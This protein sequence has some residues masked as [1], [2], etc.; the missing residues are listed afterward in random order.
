[1]WWCT[2]LI[3]A[4][5]RQRQG[6][7][8]VRGQP[9]L[10]SE[11]QDSQSYIEKPCLEN[12]QTKE[13]KTKKQKRNKKKRS[14]RKF[15][16]IS[17]SQQKFTYLV[18]RNSSNRNCS[19]TSRKSQRPGIPWCPKPGWAAPVGLRGPLPCTVATWHISSLFK[20]QVTG[21]AWWH[22]PLIPAL[23]RQRQVDFWVQGQ[24]GLQSKFQDSQGYTEKPCLEKPHTHTHTH[25]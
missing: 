11:F 18:T 23:R 24:P 13:N 3:P 2:P 8:R 12:K 14:K 10:Q 4:L 25:K 20:N 17:H 16:N 15:N 19:R 21:W 5:G 6:D 7:F 1:M 22:M 9:G